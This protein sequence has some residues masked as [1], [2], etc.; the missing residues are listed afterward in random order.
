MIFQ[1]LRIHRVR[2]S[3]E[4]SGHVVFTTQRTAEQCLLLVC[5]VTG[6]RGQKAS[7]Q[8]PVITPEHGMVKKRSSSH[9]TGI[10]LVNCGVVSRT[11]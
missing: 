11:V 7:N 3:S 6:S 10:R 4:I 9:L 8:L 1:P 5:C 2:Q